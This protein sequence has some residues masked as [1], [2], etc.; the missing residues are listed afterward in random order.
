[1]NDL[2]PRIA[3]LLAEGIEQAEFSRDLATIDRNV[4]ISVQLNDCLLRDFN[5]MSFF[6]YSKGLLL[7]LWF[8]K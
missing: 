3:N 5:K 8:L 7:N 2:K 1:L 4:D 6:Q